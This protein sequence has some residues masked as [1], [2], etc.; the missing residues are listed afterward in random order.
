VEK[1]KKER[2]DEDVRRREGWALLLLLLGGTGR[3]GRAEENEGELNWIGFNFLI[4]YT[5]YMTKC[6]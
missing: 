1:E 4:T 2:K 6:S 5:Y 3:P